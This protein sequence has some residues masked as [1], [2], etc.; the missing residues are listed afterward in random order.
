M[1]IEYKIVIPTYDRFDRFETLAFLEKNNVPREII[2]IFVASE[3]EKE[4]Y[5]NS[6]C[7]YNFIVGVLGLVEQRNFI[8]N[9]FEEGEILISMDDD[10]EDLIHKDDKPF[11]EWIQECVEYIKNNEIGILGINPS[12]NPFYFEQ[13]KNGTSF[14]KGNYSIVGC[15]QI[16]INNKDLLLSLIAIEDWERSILYAEKYGSTGRY[17]DILIK[18]KYFHKKGGLSS[19]RTKYNYLNSM[20]KLICRYPGRLSFNYKSLPLDKNILFP[21]LRFNKQIKQNIDVIQLPE[22]DAS[23]LFELY[24]ML[25]NII[26]PKKSKSTNRRGFPIGHQAMTFGYTRA[27][28]V[29]RKNGK[30]FDLSNCSLKYPEIYNEL[31]RIGNIYCPFEFTSIHVNRNVVCPKHKDSK[32]VGRSMLLSFGDYTGCNIIVND[33]IYDANCKPIIFDGAKLEHYNSD[34]LEGIKYSLVYYN[35]DHSNSTQSN[36]TNE[37]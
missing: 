5:I 24:N 17:N 21:N 8:T 15:F 28:F 29:T 4:K 1:S 13:R 18:T 22:V 12:V 32:N 35:G 2:Y 27:R 36:E 23:E 9:Y 14:K 30:L 19:Q 7:K 11:S 31:L 37:K 33:K 25:E 10:I 16:L 6:F 3:D 34:D 20:N 26:I